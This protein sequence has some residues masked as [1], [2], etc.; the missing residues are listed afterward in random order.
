[1]TGKFQGLNPR[2]AAI[3][4]I[5]LLTIAAISDSA[6]ANTQCEDSAG[7][8]ALYARC[9]ARSVCKVND[10]I[11]YSQAIPIGKRQN[12]AAQQK[13]FQAM[14]SKAAGKPMGA[15][16]TQTAGGCLRNAKSADDFIK[17]MRETSP[18]NAF[19]FLRY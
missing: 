19:I 3:G 11:Y 5:A 10:P 6:M 14:A 13:R 18:E 8:T 4:G 1:M 17:L 12:A 9:D 15:Y 7:W 16:V 2:K